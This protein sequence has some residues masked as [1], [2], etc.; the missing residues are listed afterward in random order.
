MST[1]RFT[2]VAVVLVCVGLL[3]LRSA[4]PLEAGTA[5]RMDV[6]ELVGGSDLIVDALVLSARALETGPARIET[7]YELAV[8]RTLLGAHLPQRTVRMPGG[9]L[10]DGRGLVLAGV[11]RLLVGERVLLFL[12]QPGADGMRMPV[13]LSQGKLRVQ[14]DARGAL[15]LE[16]GQSSLRLIEAGSNAPARADQ[17]VRL[18]YGSVVERIESAVAQRAARNNGR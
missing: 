5:V 3:G 15:W 12:S 9:V 1:P 14:V 17:G 16:R 7:E 10:A 13:G 11:P 8:G 6:P 2:L 4:R 18:A